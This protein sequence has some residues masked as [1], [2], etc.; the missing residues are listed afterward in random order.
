VLDTAINYRHMRSERALGRALAAAIEAGEIARDEVLLAT[1]GGFIPFEHEMPADPPG[2]FTRTYLVPGILRGEEIVARCHAMS[3]R[4][5]EDQIARSLANLGVETLDLYYLHNPETQRAEIGNDDFE[6]RLRAAFECL[7]L[8]VAEGRIGAYGL[9]TWRGFRVGCDALDYLDLDRILGLATEVG[10]ERHHL[11]AIQL[12]LNSALPEA[13]ELGTI[14]L[15]HERG[16]TVMTSAS[17]RQG[18]AATGGPPVD[19]LTPV[20]REIDGVRS[21]AGVTSALIGTT[22]PRHLRENLAAARPG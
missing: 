6:S 8:E 5:L 22:D 18:R 4:F 9:A 7:E 20:Q 21:T 14:E 12:P 3:A 17:I 11:R 16:L 2:W 19:G 15:A 13:R 1:K 10:G